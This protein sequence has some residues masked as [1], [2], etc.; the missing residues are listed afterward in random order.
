[1][2]VQS[3]INKNANIQ[4]K[5]AFV[6]LSFFLFKINSSA[7]RILVSGTEIR[8]MSCVEFKME[9]NKERKKT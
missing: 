3:D 5:T 9:L 8:L 7:W 6:V 2:I 4:I 1:M